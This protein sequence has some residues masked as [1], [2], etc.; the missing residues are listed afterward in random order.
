MT[1]SEYF[2]IVPHYCVS[3]DKFS[4]INVNWAC[5]SFFLFACNLWWLYHIFYLRA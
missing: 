5:S 2:K 3:V 4:G 1:G